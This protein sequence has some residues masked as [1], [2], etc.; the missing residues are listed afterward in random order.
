ME[1]SK[2]RI[3]KNIKLLRV[4]KKWKFSYVSNKTDIEEERL[5]KIELGKVIPSHEELYKLSRLY[6]ITIDDLVFKELE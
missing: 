5:R 3:R 2:D 4:K 1:Y 6:D